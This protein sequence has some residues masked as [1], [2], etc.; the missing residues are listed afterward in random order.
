MLIFRCCT[1]ISLELNPLIYLHAPTNTCRVFNIIIIYIYLDNFLA[2][3]FKLII[4]GVVFKSVDKL[5]TKLAALSYIW[6][7][8]YEGR[9]F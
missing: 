4:R 1:I 3:P 8:E 6:H 2:F 5:Y 7:I 9:G